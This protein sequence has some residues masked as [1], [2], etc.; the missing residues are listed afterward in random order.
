MC[1]LNFE[2]QTYID[3]IKRTPMPGSKVKV[4]SQI[5]NVTDA[6]PLTG[7]LKVH[8]NDTPDNETVSVHRDGVVLIAK[9]ER[10]ED[11]ENDD[12]KE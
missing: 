7:M 4:G 9:Q 1:C 5:G 8:L 6:N 12:V 3:E 10:S 11:V 2:N